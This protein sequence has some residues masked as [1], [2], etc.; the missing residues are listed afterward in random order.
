LQCPYHVVEIGSVRAQRD[1]EDINWSMTIIAIETS[2][3]HIHTDQG[4]VWVAIK[5][6]SVDEHQDGTRHNWVRWVKLQ[7]VPSF[8][9]LASIQLYFQLCPDGV[10]MAERNNWLPVLQDGPANATWLLRY[11]RTVAIFRK[12]LRLFRF[13]FSLA[14]ILFEGRARIP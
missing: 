10:N 3:N 5:T 14:L 13:T 1:G 7:F 2:R 6:E 8:K 9:A 12:Y 4:P 11:H